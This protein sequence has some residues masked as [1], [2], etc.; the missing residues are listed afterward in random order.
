MGRRRSCLLSSL[1]GGSRDFEALINFER[2]GARKE[3]AIGVKD[4][5]PAVGG[6]VDLLANG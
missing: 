3:V 6:A 5:L 2:I 4:F 1:R